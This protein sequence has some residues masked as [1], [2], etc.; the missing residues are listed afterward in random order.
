MTE[1]DKLIILLRQANYDI[2]RLL[3]FSDPH[4]DEVVENT[5]D[6]LLRN[7]VYIKDCETCEF[8]TDTKN[9]FMTLLGKPFKYCPECGKELNY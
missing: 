2:S 7:N 3:P 6:Y 1:R 4:S 8:L 5:A 9:Q